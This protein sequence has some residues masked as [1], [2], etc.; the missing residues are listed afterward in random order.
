MEDGSIYM[1][2]SSILGVLSLLGFLLFLGGIALV[3][4]SSSQGR[5]IRNGGL[6]A[7]AGLIVGL[8][9][10]AISQGILLVEPTEVTVIVNTLSGELDPTPRRGGTHIIVP[11]VQQPFRYPL[12][13]QTV[14]MDGDA[15]AADSGEVVARSSDG[16]EV[17]LDI[18]IIYSVD[19]V[20]VNTLHLNWQNRYPDQFVVPQARGIIRDAVS[21]FEADDIY[22]GGRE[23]L[24]DTAAERLRT[25]LAADGLVLSDLIIRDITF[26]QQYADAIEQAQVAAQE[27]QRARLV[28]QQRQ[29]EAEQRRVEAQG[30]RD[31]EVTRA[32]GQ[33]QATILQARAEA[34]A[35]RLVSEQIAANPRLV[36]YQYIQRLA[37]NIRLALVPSDS[38]FLFDFESI[39]ADPDFVAPEVP[40][41]SDLEFDDITAESTPTPSTDSP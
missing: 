15:N 4:L 10:S 19:P 23:A 36:Q 18:S 5:P 39:S 31:A 38:P 7:V 9:F 2:V 22:A 24:S 25:R 1:G 17:R 26:S 32:E 29:Q 33:A 14:T 30:L 40:A 8:L 11:V 28:V 6:L 3:V 12:V 20:N 16:Q 27:A 37:D 34:E 21:G 41:S 13:Q 35:L